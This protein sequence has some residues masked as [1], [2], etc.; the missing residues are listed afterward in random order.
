[1]GRRMGIGIEQAMAERVAGLPKTD[2]GIYQ[3]L[4]QISAVEGS[5][6]LNETFGETNKDLT[7]RTAQESVFFGSG[8][9]QSELE[10]RQI[11]R[12]AQ[13]AAV[14]GGALRTQKGT[15]GVGSARQP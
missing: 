4:T 14:P 1:M 6:I 3:D 13:R 7:E 2:A 5:G 9:A 12:N 10:R 15:V 11:E 8:E